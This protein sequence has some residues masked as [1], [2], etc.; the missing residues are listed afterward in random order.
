MMKQIVAFR[1]FANASK[2]FSDRTCRE[3]QTTHFMFNNFSFRKSCR[4]CDNVENSA[5]LDRAQTYNTVH[6]HCVLDK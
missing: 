5:E 2:N 1:N 6:V 3:N 4:L